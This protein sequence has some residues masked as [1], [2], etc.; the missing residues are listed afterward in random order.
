MILDDLKLKFLTDQ[1]HIELPVLQGDRLTFDLRERHR[2]FECLVLSAVTLVHPDL[3]LPWQRGLYR[4]MIKPDWVGVRMPSVK[5]HACAGNRLACAINNP[6]AYFS[7]GL[8]AKLL[9]FG[10]RVNFDMPMLGSVAV[11][12]NGQYIFSKFDRLELKMSLLV[13]LDR[14]I[15]VSPANRSVCQFW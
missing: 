8:Q 7:A 6:V 5:H 13:R 9:H 3:H 11:G 10:L 4:P 1:L 15:V 2:C 14:W 12:F